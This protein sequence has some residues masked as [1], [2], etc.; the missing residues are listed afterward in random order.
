MDGN[1]DLERVDALRRNY[2]NERSETE[3]TGSDGVAQKS[4][5][6]W[7]QE[8]SLAAW[9]QNSDEDNASVVNSSKASARFGRIQTRAQ[10]LCKHFGLPTTEVDCPSAVERISCSHEAVG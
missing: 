7:K 2:G 4:G 6:E 3:G 1:A 10:E 8:A 9:Q 5:T